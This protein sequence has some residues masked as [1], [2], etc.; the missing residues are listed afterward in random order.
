M[1]TF[2][3][4]L[5]QMNAAIGDLQ[6]NVRKIKGFI[7]EAQ[8]MRAD[9]VAFPELAIPG[10]PPEDLLFKPQF[11]RANIAAMKEVA[12]ASRDIVVVV[13]F[14]D[15]DPDIRNAA[16]VAYDRE[17]VD[18]YHKIYLPNYGVFD[19]VRYFKPG[20][21]CP[22]YVINGTPV[23]VNV[24]EDIW[25][26]VGPTNVQSV[27]GAELI[28]NINGSPYNAGKRNFRQKM[29]AKRSRDNGLYLAYVNL[30][31]G[32]D[33]LVFDGGSMV[34]DHTGELV[35]Q[36]G[37]FEEELILVDLDMDVIAGSRREG[38]NS[39]KN[40]SRGLS[41]VGKPTAV[42]ISDTPKGDSRPSLPA[43]TPRLYDE[44]GEVYA[45]L[46]LGTRDYVRKCGFSKVLIGL[47]GGIDSSLVTCVAVDALGKENVQV[48]A[49]PSRF[50][51]EGSI[52]D[53][54]SLAES[55]GLELWIVP[56][57]E[58]HSAYE[59]M[60][61]PHFQS[62]KPSVAE[63]N[64]QT[65]V[66]GNIL[67]ALSNK[68]GWLVLTTGN[69][70]EMAAGYA[71]LYGDM[72][73]GF[74]VIKDVPKTLVYRL[75][76]YRNTQGPKPVI[77]RSVIEK[78]PSAELKPDQKDEDTLPPYDVLDPILKAYVE[79]DL[80]FDDIVAAGFDEELVKRVISMVDRNEYKRRQAPPGIK[81]TPRNF[82]RDRRMPIANRYRPF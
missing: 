2:R 68:L 76:E 52:I 18:V 11:I 79:D 53:A 44:V 72:A 12:D 58:A 78:P 31:G 17:L 63:E 59:S 48:V 55:L 24:C 41:K 65:R 61:A 39:L 56:I 62:T 25:F 3:I 37:Q 5:A 47:S 13:G 29:L 43:R 1:R 9:M 28:I 35:A 14:A 77:P 74:A 49:M 6:S 46:V 66:R 50:S 57:E 71:T 23:G 8:A 16:A 36:G 73:G 69:K 54:K 42:H 10:Y 32:Q 7:E 20:G 4:A 45:A 21:L 75:A 33:E 38:S 19:E 70:S 40:N 15:A 30:V 51:S 80:P 67:M 81:I 26:D 60:L 64:I 82:G 22:V 34:F 27:A